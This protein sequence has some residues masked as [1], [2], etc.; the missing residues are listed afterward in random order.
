MILFCHLLSL[1]VLSQPARKPVYVVVT[2]EIAV[3]NRV[4][5]SAIDRINKTV[6][7]Y[8]TMTVY[9][10]PCKND[11][12]AIRLVHVEKKKKAITPTGNKTGCQRVRSSRNKTTQRYEK[13]YLLR[14]QLY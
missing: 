8:D 3:S 13:G 5:P 2:N 11:S 4:V 10:L 6:V 12:R 9:T 7:A 14:R 1:L